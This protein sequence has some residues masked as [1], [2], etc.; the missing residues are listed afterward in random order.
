MQESSIWVTLSEALAL[1]GVSRK[2]LYRYMDRGL[3]S[4]RKA[5]NGHRYLS[6][7]EIDA[8]L[9]SHPANANI[10]SDAQTQDYSALIKQLSELNNKIDRQNQ[11]LEIMIELYKPETMHELMVKR[12]IL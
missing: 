2:T 12:K 1:L 5:A 11:L 6:K 8:F 7:D 3:L 10:Q 4:Y 9:A